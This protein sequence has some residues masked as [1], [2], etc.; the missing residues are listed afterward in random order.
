MTPGE[1][2]YFSCRAENVAEADR[3]AYR[4]ADGSEYPDPASRWQPDG[5]HQPS[6][7]WFPDDFA[8]TDASWR[9]VAREKLVLY[10]LH[11]GTFTAE[12]TFEAIIAR[13]DELVSLGI[14]ALEIM[15]VAQ[16]PGT[17]NWGYDGV[18]PYAVQRSYGGPRGLQRLVDA[19]HRAG[20]AV[21]LD[22]VY[23]HLGPEGNYS[24]KFGPYFTERY[25]TPW[26]AA[27]NFDDRHSDAVRRYFLDNACMWIRDFHVDGLRLDSVQMMFDLGATH[28]LAEIQAAVHEEGKRQNRIVH[29]IGETSAND[30]RLIAPVECGGYGLDGVWADDFHHSIHVLL[31]GEHDGYYLDYGSL[32]H[33]AKAFREV[34]VYDGCFSQFRGRRHGSKVGDCDRSKFVVCIQNHDQVGNR[35]RG[36]RL[37]TIVSPAACRLACALTLLSPCTPLLFMGEEY[38]EERPFPFFCSFGDADLIDCVRRGRCAEFATLAFRWAGEIPDPQAPETFQSAVLQW[39]W[40][41]DSPQAKRRRLYQ[42][43]LAARRVWPALCDR[44]PA[45][46]RADE[47]GGPGGTL[48]RFM[49]IERGSDEKIVVFANFGDAPLPLPQAA[50][51]ERT[52]LLS[53]ENSRYGGQRSSRPTP[54]E[55]LPHE[56]LI[57]GDRPWQLPTT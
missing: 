24:A 4:F 11:V 43:L 45:L 13:L 19:A 22:V 31:T 6:A 2:G 47:F 37:S 34:F 14:T 7:V 50:I 27:V 39:S 51:G 33:V 41:P 52:L 8:W 30:V 42:D 3:Y 53:T 49:I 15:P 48:F 28:I 56:L 10:E 1:F 29:V 21:L 5:V 54:V 20:L 40:L 32:E 46:A 36:D 35:S 55:I 38:G 12:G 17:R 9:G 18:Y 57:F 26:G 23:N 44:Q 16:F 25:R